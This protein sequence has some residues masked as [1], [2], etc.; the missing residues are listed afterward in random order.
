MTPL[1]KIS[2][3]ATGCPV[4]KQR[5]TYRLRLNRVC[6]MH[7]IGICFCWWLRFATCL[8]LIPGLVKDHSKSLSW[9]GVIHIP[10]TKL[11][12]RASLVLLGG[13]K[14]WIIKITSLHTGSFKCWSENYSPLF[15]WENS[16]AF[17][18]HISWYTWRC[19]WANNHVPKRCISHF[20][21]QGA[22][23]IPNKC[24]Q[25]VLLILY[26]W[27]MT[28]TIAHEVNH[29]LKI[30]HIIPKNIKSLD[31]GMGHQIHI[32]VWNREWLNFAINGKYYAFTV[33]PN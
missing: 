20:L 1:T 30:F 31:Y 26:P 3:A 27:E 17:N 33:W 29:D 25:R 24:H 28:S 10:F 6:S 8:F 16:D 32:T 7:E 2:G 23:N 13:G 21:L 5:T 15:S 4:N 12:Q 9:C 22:T 14:K 18:L 19:V 11:R